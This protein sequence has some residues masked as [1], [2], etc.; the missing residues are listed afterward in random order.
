MTVAPG[1]TQTVSFS[2][3]DD[4]SLLIDHPDVWWPI[5][6]GAH[7]LYG[8]RT[9]LDQRGS[10][11]DS[12]SE[13]FGIRTISTR[14]VGASPIA[15]QGSRQ[16]LVN[17]VPFVF[18][19]GG[20]SEDLFLRYSSAD[21]ADQIAMIRNLGLNGIRTEGKQLPDDFYEQMDRAG[22]LVDAGFQCCD[23]WQLQDSGL[24][25]DHDFAV[26]ELSA[27]TIGQNLRNHPSILNF[28]WSDNQ[29]TRRQEAVSIQGFQQADF[30][31]P[32]I[33]S[34]EYKSSPQLGPSGE[35]EGPYDW[36]P[37]SY[38][39]DTSHYDPGDSSRTNVGGAWAFDSEA[40]TGHTVP[41]LDSI[42]RF[43]SPLQQQSCG[44][45]RTT[46]STTPTTSPT[47]RARQRRLLVRD[48][49]R[50]R[51][52][53]QQRYGSWSSLDQ[54]VEEAQVQNYET[55]RA[56]FEAY[57]DHSTKQDAPSTGIVYW[58]LN[59]GWPTL[60]WDLYNH[61]FDQAGSYF[62]AK[63]ANEPLHVLYAYDDGSVS[64]D[65]LGNG[66]RDGLSVQA[67]VYGVDGKLLDDQ[68]ARGVS[69]AGQGVAT[70]VLHPSVPAATTPPAAPKTYFVELLLRRHGAVVD[71]NVYW[72]S[73]QQDE[74]DWD[75]TIGN[76][77]ATM[78]QFANLSQL[79]GL[80]PRA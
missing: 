27:L 24:T 47:S 56:E 1:A 61:D 36:V 9:E 18:R 60:L 16:F 19:G 62:G 10:A 21:T 77:Q 32:L 65:N 39:Y 7:P 53:D 2:P 40:G 30:Q 38:W 4:A 57:I 25:S 63:K 26:L 13:T 45:T 64:V 66:D 59:K 44:R 23:A 76:P 70:G 52:R 11:P 46:T 15:P 8:L 74:V 51:H 55:Q 6:M 73:T 78:S 69:V 54:Y 37:P 48:A 14:L 75:K 68:T 35:K 12:Q 50:P 17:G 71:R 43:M 80:A 67:K 22:M 41:T 79:Q 20:W 58:Q 72:L 34:A 28:S 31:E 3:G 49:A 5:G 33:A 29:P 42:R